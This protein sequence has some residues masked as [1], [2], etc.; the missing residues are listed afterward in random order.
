MREKG[1]IKIERGNNLLYSRYQCFKVKT[2]P[3]SM[4]HISS[5]RRLSMG[6]YE[7]ATSFLIDKKISVEI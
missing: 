6:D 7:D 3:L 4:C 2:G 1:A 5:L